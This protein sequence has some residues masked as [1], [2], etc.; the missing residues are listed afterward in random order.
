MSELVSSEHRFSIILAILL[1]FFGLSISFCNT[2]E[3]NNNKDRSEILKA[4][5]VKLIPFLGKPFKINDKV[6]TPVQLSQFGEEMK[7]MCLA[8]D[9]DRLFLDLTSL[10]ALCK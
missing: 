9:D 5:E 3:S 4:Q 2:Y 8:A 6:Y 1:I 10:N 7:L